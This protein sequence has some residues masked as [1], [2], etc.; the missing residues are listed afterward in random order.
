M[1]KLRDT[2]YEEIKNAFVTVLDYYRL[3][4]LRT[5]LNVWASKGYLNT[6]ALL[7]RHPRFYYAIADNV[8]KYG[9]VME[10]HQSN[11]GVFTVVFSGHEDYLLEDGRQAFAF[12]K[13]A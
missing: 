3:Q 13:A 12:K 1:I 2:A 5:N 7:A 10:M 9:N 4:A 11:D 8:K 6:L